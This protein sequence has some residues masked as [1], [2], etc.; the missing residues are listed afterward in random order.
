MFFV[1]AVIGVVG[2]VV[3]D[4]DG[5]VV[6]VVVLGLRGHILVVVAWMMI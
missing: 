3:I 1:F 4:D 6:V 2:V 5:V